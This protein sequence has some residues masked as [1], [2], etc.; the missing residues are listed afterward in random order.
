[1]CHTKT[2]IKNVK[3]VETTTSTP[4]EEMLPFTYRV[5]PSFSF[6]GQYLRTQFLFEILMK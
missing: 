6:P 1:M 3:T 5:T 4:K 2:Q